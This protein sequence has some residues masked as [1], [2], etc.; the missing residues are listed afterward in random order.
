MSELFRFVLFCFVFFPVFSLPCE[1]R[2][3]RQP[4]MKQEES[5]LLRPVGPE[6]MSVDSRQLPHL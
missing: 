6:T 2:G 5:P 4:F 1:D 3:R